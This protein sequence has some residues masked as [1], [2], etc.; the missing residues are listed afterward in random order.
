VNALRFILW[1]WWAMQR[2]WDLKLLWPALK[3]EAHNPDEAKAAFALHAMMSPCWIGHYG[4]QALREY[5]G[6]LQ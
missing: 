4:E 1:P 2:R 3:S 6:R 5:I